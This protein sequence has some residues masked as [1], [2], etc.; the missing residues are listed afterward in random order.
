MK[1]EGELR[2]LYAD[3][4]ES[5][6]DADTLRLIATLDA[7]Y[8]KDQPPARFI[9]ETARLLEQRRPAQRRRAFAS[10]VAG[11][12]FLRER[13]LL[14][15]VAIL[16]AALLVTAS[17]AYAATSLIR[18]WSPERPPTHDVVFISNS[19]P[20][21]GFQRYRA[22]D[23]PRAAR[24]SGLPVAY[25][26]EIPAPLKGTVGVQF[27]PPAAWPIAQKTMPERMRSAVRYRG[28]GHT[29]I[30]ALFE[31]APRVVEKHPVLV[32]ERTVHLPNGDDAWATTAPWMVESNW[33]SSV[34]DG[35]I[36]SLYSDL[37]MVEVERLATMVAIIPP[38]GD[39]SSRGIPST[40]PTA[41]PA[42][43]P[44]PG[45]DIALMGTVGRDLSSHPPR[46]TYFL[47][48]GNRG[49]GHEKHL[50]LTL[51]LPP[52]LAFAGET[53]RREH[54]MAL[55]PGTGGIG[56]DLPLVITDEHAFEHGIDV[57]L[58]WTEN[59]VN[60]ER[61]FHLPIS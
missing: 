57:R 31:L 34:R 40:W 18:V 10:L 56:G 8:G 54:T 28:N 44:I 30:V 37:P 17:V 38:S 5:D 45:V 41:L 25:L 13:P 22:L 46:L 58:T 23:P 47:E 35:Y 52:G 20:P 16:L 51:V 49:R 55:R 59:G 50:T 14:G 7:A 6:A 33:V 43:T 36:V 1:S 15:T 21:L 2:A 60:G 53:P 29:L 11:R 4:V 48:L 12:S 39:A 9:A 19:L 3:L 26:S 27:M 42:D 32:G 24:E 61:T